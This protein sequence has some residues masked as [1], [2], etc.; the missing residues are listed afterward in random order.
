VNNTKKY[1]PKD[2]KYYEIYNAS[3]GFAIQDLNYSSDLL[4]ML[5]YG[6]FYEFIPMDTFGTMEQKLSI[7]LMWNCLPICF[8]NLLILFCMIVLFVHVIKSVPH[9]VTGNQTSH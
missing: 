6:I 7:E 1:C 8:G 2:F 5:D 3:E 9:W 4:L